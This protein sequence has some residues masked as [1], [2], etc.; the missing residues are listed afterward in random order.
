[1]TRLKT[2]LLCGAFA[3]VGSAAQAQ[4]VEF[5]GAA[6]GT[7]SYNTTNKADIGQDGKGY[8]SVGGFG[9]SIESYSHINPDSVSFKSG[10]AVAGP[11]ASASVTSGV[12]I[13]FSNTN[14]GLI[15]LQDFG[16]TI[17]PAGFGFFLQDRAPAGLAD[18]YKDYGQTTTGATF[19]DFADL[20]GPNATLATADFEFS[21]TAPTE[22]AT[23]YSVY[24]SIA[25]KTNYYGGFYYSFNTSDAALKLS[26]FRQEDNSDFAQTFRWDAKDINVPLSQLGNLSGYSSLPVFYSTTITAHTYAGCINDGLTCLVSYAAFG[27]PIGRGGAIDDLLTL[28]SMGSFNE[29]DGFQ[30]TNWA[31]AGCATGAI[32]NLQYNEVTYDIY[33][34]GGENAV[35][36]P[37]TW[38]LLIS[39]FGFAGQAL[40]RRRRVS[41][42]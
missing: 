6:S 40:R 39:G 3:A 27:D 2:M 30:A 26:N 18:V 35:P 24:G 23:L 31:D 22:D 17:I 38:A 7:A 9:G 14:D 4:T 33:R 25:L 13:L 19:Q 10:G 20:I 12:G 41:Y 1:M 32:C 29:L 36:E 16:S 8:L 37:A 34:P 28:D 11:D 15:A 5:F 42:T 21:I